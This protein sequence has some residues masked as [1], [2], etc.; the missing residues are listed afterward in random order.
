MQSTTARV[1]VAV[2]TALGTFLVASW[3]LAP[4]GECVVLGEPSRWFTCP[5]RFG[6]SLPAMLI[7]GIS[8]GGAVAIGLMTWFVS[9]RRSLS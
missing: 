2:I 8:V 1:T 4:A 3:V 5:N 7:A 9:R 6:H